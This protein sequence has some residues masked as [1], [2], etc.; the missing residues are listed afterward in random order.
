MNYAIIDFGSNTIRLSIYS[1]KHGEIETVISQ[2]EVV[3]LAGY[4]KENRLEAEGIQRTCDV[5]QG[6]KEIATR[7]VEKRISTYS[8]PLHCAE[9]ITASKRSKRSSLTVISTRRFCR[10]RKKP[11]WDFLEPLMM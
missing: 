9:F 11:V 4:V 8:Q 7:F 6:F 5:L 2:K 1:Q 3:G 10:E